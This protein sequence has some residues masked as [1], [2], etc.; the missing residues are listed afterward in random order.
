[1]D[2]ESIALTTRPRL[3]LDKRIVRDSWAKLQWLADN[4]DILVLFHQTAKRRQTSM[5][6]W[7]LP[8]WYYWSTN[9]EQD[10]KQHNRRHGLKK[11]QAIYTK[12]GFMQQVHL[13]IRY[14]HIRY[15]SIVFR[16]CFLV[17][18]YLSFS[19]SFLPSR[20]FCLLNDTYWTQFSSKKR[21]HQNSTAA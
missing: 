11:S 17:R 3:P 8:R 13:E 14:V 21:V 4:S 12:N 16:Q 9:Q 5:I 1:M 18:W 10:K 6:A 15:V 19:M 2:F 7:H 20:L